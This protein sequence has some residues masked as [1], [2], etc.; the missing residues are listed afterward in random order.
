MLRVTFYSYKGGT[1]RTLAML[2]V[3][4]L[5]A[6]RGRRVLLVDLDLEAPGLDFAAL[7]RS[8]TGPPDPKRPGVS[9]FLFD[10]QSSSATPIDTYINPI[11]TEHFHDRL[12]VMTVG[13]RGVE[14]AR[15]VEDIFREP[16]G[17]S[18]H[19]FALLNAEIEAFIA[20]DYVFFD[21]RTGLAD[22]AGVC[23]MELPDV[24]VAFCGL[25][26]QNVD[27]MAWALAQMREYWQAV[28]RDVATL[29]VLSPVPREADLGGLDGQ[30]ESVRNMLM[31]LRDRPDEIVAAIKHHPLWARIYEAESRLLAPLLDGL[32]R[33][34]PRFPRL[35]R[36]D[37][38]HLFEYD[39]WI[40]LG[41]ALIAK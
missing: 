41:D 6:E 5:L 35:D 17:D 40:T 13:T 33:I 38:L 23:T 26:E 20:P 1:G 25:S 39:P 37:L 19:L 21:S 7:T 8:A 24:V 22:V 12:Q 4:A 27:G 28:S 32:P 18:A 34:R 3:A 10:R 15:T 29:L 30:V 11:I 2:N 36:E 31:S 14:F 16:Q 9:D